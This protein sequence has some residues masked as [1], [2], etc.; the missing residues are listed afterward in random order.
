MWAFSQNTHCASYSNKLLSCDVRCLVNPSIHWAFKYRPR[1]RESILCKVIFIQQY[2]PGYSKYPGYVHT[3]KSV[4]RRMLLN[5]LL[6]R[7]VRNGIIKSYEASKYFGEY[8]IFR[9]PVYVLIKRHTIIHRFYDTDT[10]TTQQRMCS[11][12]SNTLYNY[13]IDSR[14]MFIHFLASTPHNTNPFI[15]SRI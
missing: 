15:K 2:T 10:G 12:T 1:T 7:L 6:E 3:L 11:S 4:N 8:R 5:Y 9:I 13:V 14:I